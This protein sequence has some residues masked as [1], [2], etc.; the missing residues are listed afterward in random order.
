MADLETLEVEVDVNEAYIAQIRSGQPARIILDAYPS[1]RYAGVVRLV[2]PTA[3]RQRATVQVK[4]SIVEG[5]ERILPEMGAR[6]EFLEDPEVAAA[7]AASPRRIF[8]PGATVRTVAGE[9]VVWLVR[10][11]R[12]Y[13]ASV[14]AGPVSGGRREIRSGLTG[15]E[16]VIMTGFED[17]QDGD[18]VQVV[19]GE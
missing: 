10:D 5:N 15:G 16:Q 3:N 19:T 17:L 1:E 12:A 8:V 6:V 4:V 2:V 9:T 14:E 11:G 18:A 13:T 7:A